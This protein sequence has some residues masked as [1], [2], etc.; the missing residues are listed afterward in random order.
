MH[1][2][3]NIDRILIMKI[4]ICEPTSQI[5]NLI[6]SKLIQIDVVPL[7]VSNVR[8]VISTLR[9]TKCDLLLIDG[10]EI[11]EQNE[12]LEIISMI[13]NDEELC[14]V[15]I[16]CHVKNISKDMVRKLVSLGVC[17]FIPKPFSEKIFIPRFNRIVD[18]LYSDGSNRRS[19]IRVVPKEDVHVAGRL[20]PNYKLI[21]EKIINISIRGFL[22]H[23]SEETEKLIAINEVLESLT[24]QLPATQIQFQASVVAK[25]ERFIGFKFMEL[26]SYHKD[27]LSEYI[28]HNLINA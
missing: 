27:V 20:P 13:K 2:S 21:S 8:S 3:W 28:Y 24:I 14:K 16:I 26:S 4:I 12:N 6:A 15:N 10:P 17:G 25:K 22:S 7:I 1:F 23:V 19:H 5:A 9:S 18:Q 11:N